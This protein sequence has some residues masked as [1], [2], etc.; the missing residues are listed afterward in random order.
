MGRRGSR[1]SRGD[2]ASD[3][4]QPSNDA[5]KCFI[6]ECHEFAPDA[7]IVKDTLFNAFL[8]WI[9][10]EGKLAGREIHNYLSEA[11]SSDDEGRT[12]LM[13]LNKKD[14]KQYL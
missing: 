4:E 12:T 6:A 5:V 1:Y 13:V 14:P 8:Q 3:G 7:S 9:A 10:D 11:D 2:Q